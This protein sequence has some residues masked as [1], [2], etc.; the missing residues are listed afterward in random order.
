MRGS[1]ADDS[2][3]YRQ[4][5]SGTSLLNEQLR[6]GVE[7]AWTA[8]II[9]HWAYIVA[10]SVYAY[11]V[12]GEAAVGLRA[13][14]FRF[15]PA[16]LIAPF[17]GLLGQPLRR[18]RVLLGVNLVRLR[19]RRRG[20]RCCVF[21]DADPVDR[22]RRSQWATAIATTPYRCARKPRV[23]P[24]LARSPAELG[25]GECGDEHS[26]E[27]AAFIGP[28]LAGLSPQ[29]CEYGHGVRGHGGAGRGLRPCSC[30]LAS[31]RPDRERKREI[32]AADDHL[33]G[34]RGLH[35][36]SGREPALRVMIGPDYRADSCRRGGCRC[37]SSSRRSMSPRIRQRRVSVTSTHRSASER[38]SGGCSPSR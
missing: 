8:H 26:R 36:R 38:S 21:L 12:G 11:G 33:R 1:A 13:S 31:T 20:R 7:L 4:P 10:V 15:V 28:A 5:P 24:S 6:A 14:F 23:A 29:P 18:E 16:A 22:L 27:R 19:P 35:G 25:R 30:S 3:R 9:G 37:T 32:E 17:G 2:R 34:T